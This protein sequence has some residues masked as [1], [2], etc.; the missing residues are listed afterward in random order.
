MTNPIK[1]IELLP[2][3]VIAGSR[4]QFEQWVK[5]RKNR[6]DYVYCLNVET[7]DDRCFR[8]V[9]YVGSWFKHIERFEIDKRVEEMR[10][11]K[12]I[13]DANE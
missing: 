4:N 12:R 5:H 11:A 3:L 6:K 9:Y 10:K 8:G 2:M 1:G 7:M 13:G